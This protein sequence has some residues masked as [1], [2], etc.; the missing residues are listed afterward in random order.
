MLSKLSIFSKG[1]A[2][3]SHADDVVE[4]T[5]LTT[6]I[7]KSLLTQFTFLS[8]GEVSGWTCERRRSDRHDAREDIKIFDS[9]GDLVYMGRAFDGRT[10]SFWKP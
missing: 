2:A 5:S 7:T 10:I 3:V 1:G 6:N 4:R 8:A 9:A